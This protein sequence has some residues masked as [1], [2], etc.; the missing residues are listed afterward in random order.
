MRQSL[1][2][3]VWLKNAWIYIS[4]DLLDLDG[5][6]KILAKFAM[7]TS[8]MPFVPNKDGNRVVIRLEISNGGNQND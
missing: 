6:D 5:D 4:G 8:I 2:L 3:P 7:R 1:I